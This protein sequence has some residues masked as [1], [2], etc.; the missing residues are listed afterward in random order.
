MKIFSILL[1]LPLTLAAAEPL[2]LILP[3]DNRALYDGVPE[4][5][6]MYVLRYSDK[7]ASKH[8][9]AGQYGFVRTVIKTEKDGTIATQFHEGLDIKPTKRDRSGNPLDQVRAIADGE[10]VHVNNSAG[11]SS[12]GKYLVI[13]HDFDCGPF[14][15]LY[16]HLSRVDIKVGEKVIGG[17]PIGIM[18]Y[19]GAGINRARAHLHLEFCML[20][21]ENFIDWIGA[22]TT[23]GIYDGRNL[24]GIDIAS[25]FL[26]TEASDQ[27][28]I[29]SFL[30]SASPY[31]K[32]AIPRKNELEITQRY[33]WLQKGDHTSPSPSWEISFTD[34][35]IPLSVVPS[36]REVSQATITYVRT[37]RSKHEFYTRGRLTGAGRKAS[38]SKSGRKFIALFTNEYTKPK[39]STKASDDS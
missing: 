32:V 28:T 35:G 13:K 5:F 7:K 24:I 34:S 15:S 20:S 30:E 18:G 11:G 22:R 25:L 2:K 36:H 14:F 12:Y 29:P 16:A 21:T 6:Y 37:T 10:I 39:T 9:T 31:F 38:L 8:W 26:A 17:F 3:T 1:L 19:T 4:D 23:H 33:P 27:V